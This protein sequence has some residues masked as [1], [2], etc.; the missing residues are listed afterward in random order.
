MTTTESKKSR[1][2][3]E[4]HMSRLREEII[5]RVDAFLAAAATVHGDEGSIE[6]RLTGC[7]V[8]YDEA[9][10]PIVSVHVETIERDV[11]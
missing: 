9:D 5:A 4:T 10:E 6:L 8:D 3:E 11:L 7:V 2:I 1:P